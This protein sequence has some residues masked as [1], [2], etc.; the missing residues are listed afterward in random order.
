MGTSSSN[1]IIILWLLFLGQKTFDTESQRQSP[2]L[3]LTERMC[4]AE[5]LEVAPHFSAKN[6]VITSI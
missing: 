5:S 3:A 6:E 2:P 4:A 1:T